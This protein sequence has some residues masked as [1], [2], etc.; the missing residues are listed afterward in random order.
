MKALIPF[1]FL[2]AVGIAGVAAGDHESPAPSPISP[3]R[4][5][6]DA[7][8]SVDA[9]FETGVLL[10]NQAH[11]S[12]ARVAVRGLR[13]HQK[14]AHLPM[15][16][17][18]LLDRSGSMRGDGKMARAIDAACQAIDALKE[19][20]TFTAMT[21]DDG[22]NVVTSGTIDSSQ[23]VIGQRELACRAL[24]DIGPRG[25]TDMRAGL[26][27]VQ[28]LSTSTQDEHEVR[29]LLLLSDG[30]PDS[31]EGLVPLA[32]SLARSGIVTTTIGL[33]VDY[34]EDLMAGIA[35]AGLGNTY[36][37]GTG[38]GSAKAT[39]LATIFRT[40]LSNMCDVV[41]RRTRV[42]LVPRAGLELTEVVGFDSERAKDGS[43]FVDIGDVYAEHSTELLVR[44]K[45]PSREGQAT[46]LDV[47]VSGER[48]RDGT[49]FAAA[50]AGVA[51]F[52]AD[53]AVVSAS[54][55]AVVLEDVEEWK[56]SVALL[57]ANEAYNRG[58]FGLGDSILTH[59]KVAVQQQ[60]LRL[61]SSKLGAL[62]NEVD[63]Y[64]TD[65]ASQG[66]AGRASLNKVA[67]EK[68]RDWNRSSK[69]G[70]P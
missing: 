35:D 60:A 44:V 30:H 10:A 19:G 55:N 1:A 53:S 7:P 70:G 22:A 59:Q 62:V 2:G 27:L 65:N 45:T 28:Q 25:S 52:S 66:E 54:A 11:D 31:E 12:F 8:V 48:S 24:A 43:V 16:L 13:S 32:R 36:F 9:A 42:R 29:R 40:E 63:V 37:V 49:R 26:A 69:K 58:D 61:G 5:V 50:A 64:Q 17:M 68:A 67:K 57:R 56:T 20:D 34:N 14:Q 6:G 33:G 21:F 4:V 38:H 23:R 47:E 41:A 39:P 3:V 51:D 15:H 18:L 46:L